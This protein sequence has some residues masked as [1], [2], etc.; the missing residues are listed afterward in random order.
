[1]NNMYNSI[2][3]IIKV[4]SI[5]GLLSINI[6]N[7]DEKPSVQF[8]KLYILLP[9]TYMSIT[10]LLI[11]EVILSVPTLK[12]SKYGIG[13]LYIGILFISIG[14]I[15]ALY[16]IYFMNTLASAF[17]AKLIN[18]I[19]K[20]DELMKVM[21]NKINYRSHF[22]YEIYMISSNLVIVLAQIILHYLNLNSQQKLLNEKMLF[23]FALPVITRMILEF[24]YSL[25]VKI[26][27]E[28]FVILNNEL[29]N[30]FEC[31]FDR[32]HGILSIQ[33]QENNWKGTRV[34]NSKY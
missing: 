3:P 23:L 29:Y 6:V 19:S 15:L 28:R 34:P 25:F 2:T 33:I 30:L 32:K 14:N 31:R 24:Q 27:H 1:M 8:S 9:A 17:I 10:T 21:V 20:A 5:F 4:S 7:H 26:L 13:I 22:K 11:Y 16:T 18:K 12:R